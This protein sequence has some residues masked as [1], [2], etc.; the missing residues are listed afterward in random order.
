M[1]RIEAICS[2]LNDG[3]IHFN[4]KIDKKPPYGGY[5]DGRDGDG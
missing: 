2:F 3:F 4:N 5:I 1:V